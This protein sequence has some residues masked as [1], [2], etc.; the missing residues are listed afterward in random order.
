MEKEELIAKVNEQVR[1]K[2]FTA[3]IDKNDLAD[4]LTAIIEAVFPDVAP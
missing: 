2:I 4:I 3:N 1:D